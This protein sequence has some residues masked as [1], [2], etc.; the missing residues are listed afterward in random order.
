MLIHLFLPFSFFNQ[1]SLAGA[2]AQAMAMRKQATHGSDDEDEEEE[3][4][5]WGD[6][7][8]FSD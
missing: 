3:D 4:D 1:N 6:D 2:L 7:D 8:D 5:D